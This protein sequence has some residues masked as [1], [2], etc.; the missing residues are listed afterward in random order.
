MNGIRLKIK[1]LIIFT[2]ETG[3]GLGAGYRMLEPLW[4]SG[5]LALERVGWLEV[6]LEQ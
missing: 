2:L 3:G 1:I 4:Q 6:E 5:S